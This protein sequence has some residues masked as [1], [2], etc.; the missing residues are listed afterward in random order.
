[1]TWSGEAVCIL[2]SDTVIHS[3]HV[4]SNLLLS[5]VIPI[6]IV[7]KMRLAT[8]GIVYDHG[9]EKLRPD[10]VQDTELSPIKKDEERIENNRLEDPT[11]RKYKLL[12]TISLCVTNILYV[13]S[14]LVLKVDCI[15]LRC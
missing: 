14:Y 4:V 13:I 10:V 15:I 3:L 8:P 7:I 2:T 1:M 6:I 9:C 5:Q 12:M 11:R